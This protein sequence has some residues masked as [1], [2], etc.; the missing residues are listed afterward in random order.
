MIFGS[1]DNLK[2]HVITVH[3]KLKNFKCTYCEIAYGQKGDLNRH[4]KRVHDVDLRNY[5]IKK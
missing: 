3:D 1:K 4:V 2:K 5:E